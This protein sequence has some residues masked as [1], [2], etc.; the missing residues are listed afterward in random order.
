MNRK[1]T[2]IE[3]S[4]RM[5][6]KQIPTTIL[7]QTIQVLG[8]PIAELEREIKK[9]L[10]ENPVIEV[11]EGTILERQTQQERPEIDIIYQTTRLEKV[12]EFD[13]ITS[14]ISDTFE[15]SRVK[16]FESYERK[17]ENVPIFESVLSQNETLQEHLIFQARLDIA[18]E[19][20]FT[21]ATYIIYEI[22]DKGYFKG[23][24][25]DFRKIEGYEFTDEEIERVRQRI[26]EYDPIG[27]GSR[28]VEEALSIQ[29]EKY[30][31]K[32]PYLNVYKE[33]INN[34]LELLASN[35]K[36]II[37][38]YNIPKED[39]QK[40]MEIIK[41]LNPTPGANFSKSQD[42]IIPEAIIRKT[43][44]NDLEI[45]F[46]DTYI[47][48]LKIRK[49]YIEAIKKSK[50]KELKEK[51]VKAKNLIVSVE[52]RKNIV[53]SIIQK[54][55]EHQKPFLLGKQEFLNPLLIEDLARELEVTVSTISRGIKDKY[56]LTPVGLLPIKYFFSRS[57]KSIIG[58]EISVDKVKKMI[59]NLIKNEGNKPLSDEKISS[60]LANKGIKIARR[61]VTKYRESIGIPP[62]H[63]RKK[64]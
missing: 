14:E 19:R 51:I 30:Y 1:V 49:D 11:D 21:L 53:K 44:D 43:E 32:I 31:P 36:E 5:N 22:D 58:E 37:S 9:E 50:S 10:E 45:E 40:L 27:C 46:N 20:L 56:I 12:D 47:P 64:K 25:E 2:K 26:K 6:I 28:T 55:V 3:Q 62:A 39:L 61:T 59:E 4:L 17:S 8:L 35:P 33:I 57:G 7:S 16:E 38:K 34:D 24:I 23:N 42:F 52:Y 48:K 29:I 60:I 15:L 41:F 54:I 63:L 13:N 18:D